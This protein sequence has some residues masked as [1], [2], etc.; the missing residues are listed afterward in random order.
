LDWIN[1]HDPDDQYLGLE[2]CWR[3]FWRNVHLRLHTLWFA[4]SASLQQRQRRFWTESENLEAED[5]CLIGCRVH[6]ERIAST[7]LKSFSRFFAWTNKI[8]FKV[9]LQGRSPGVL[10]PISPA[11]YM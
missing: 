2:R 4:T 10:L 7:G 11:I 8:H 1:I 3:R 6:K 9:F 5:G